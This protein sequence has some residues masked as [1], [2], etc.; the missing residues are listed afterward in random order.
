MSGTTIN[1]IVVRRTN[2]ND[3]SYA[4]WPI[5]GGIFG[6][7]VIGV[8]CYAVHVHESLVD[9]LDS[10]DMVAFSNGKSLPVSVTLGPFC[11]T[12]A[13]FLNCVMRCPAAYEAVG[14]KRSA[15]KI[16][17]F[18]KKPRRRWGEMI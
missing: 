3:N 15:E 5:N 9:K 7:G 6:P 8:Q 4:V 12:E 16:E 11:L 2:H 18:V 14:A 17:K 1:A 10:L 13:K